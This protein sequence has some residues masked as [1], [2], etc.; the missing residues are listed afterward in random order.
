M[1]ERI[2]EKTI[3]KKLNKGKVIILMGARQT[4]KTTLLKN[5]CKKQ[6]RKWNKKKKKK[7]NRIKNYKMSSR[8]KRLIFKDAI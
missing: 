5:L 1:I 7:L 6:N 8:P 4:G 2:L 3:L